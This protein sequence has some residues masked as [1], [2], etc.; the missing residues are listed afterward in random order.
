MDPRVPKLQATHQ[1]WLAPLADFMKLNVDAVI[2]KNDGKASATT[3]ARYTS[4]V[5]LGGSVVVV[6]GM[7]EAKTMEALVVR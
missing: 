2:F 7:Y 5:F 4:G 3:I 1:H 6:E